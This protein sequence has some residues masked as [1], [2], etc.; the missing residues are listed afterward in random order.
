MAGDQKRHLFRVP[1]EAEVIELY[2]LGLSP[3]VIERTLVGGAG[4]DYL[5]K[6][7]QM[8]A[9]STAGLAVYYGI[10]KPTQADARLRELYS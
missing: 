8:T 4:L 10:W 1:C 9:S 2:R 3:A 7:W 6:K 5:A